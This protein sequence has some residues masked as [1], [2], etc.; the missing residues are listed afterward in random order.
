[1][2]DYSEKVSTIFKKIK[3]NNLEI[4]KFSSIKDRLL[5]ALT[6]MSKKQAKNERR[7]P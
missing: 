6:S 1:M 5:T 4:Q 7:M 3:K 2:K